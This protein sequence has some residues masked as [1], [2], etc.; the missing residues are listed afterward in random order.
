LGALACP[1]SRPAAEIEPE[2]L[3]FDDLQV[4]VSTAHLRMVK[5]HVRPNVAADDC[6]WLLQN[7]YL[8]LVRVRTLNDEFK[9]IR[10]PAGIQKRCHGVLTMKP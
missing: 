3:T 4:D 1:R 9:R 6:K 7:A 8:G 10:N 2:S 5:N